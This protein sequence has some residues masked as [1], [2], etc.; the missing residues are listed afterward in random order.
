[1]VTVPSVETD[2]SVSTQT[3]WSSEKDHKMGFDWNANLK[4]VL[5]CNYLLTYVYTFGTVIIVAHILQ[6]F[7]RLRTLMLSVP[8]HVLFIRNNWLKQQYLFNTNVNTRGRQVFNS[9]DPT[10]VG[11]RGS[12][13]FHTRGSSRASKNIILWPTGISYFHASRV[14]GSSKCTS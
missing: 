2:P 6:M 8:D 13:V 5:L 3:E 14:H 11:N 9:R 12:T 4:M 7:V 10:L 1:M